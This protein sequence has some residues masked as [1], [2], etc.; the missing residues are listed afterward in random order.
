MPEEEG[1]WEKTRLH[2][3]F[4]RCLWVNF[5]YATSTNIHPSYCLFCHR[6]CAGTHA[7]WAFPALK[8]FYCGLPDHF[9]LSCPKW[10][11]SS[12]CRY[13]RGYRWV[14]QLLILNPG[15]CSLCFCRLTRLLKPLQ[16]LVDFGVGQRL[17]DWELAKQLHTPLLA[18]ELP[19]LAKA[20]NHNQNK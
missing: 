9:L 4:P 8:C 7:N 3:P 13:V 20:V 2:R 10:L 6:L 19:I 15:Y 5:R 12:A 1:S 18:L 16:A 11:K 17:V 14:D